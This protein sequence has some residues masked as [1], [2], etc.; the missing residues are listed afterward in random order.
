[1]L[2]VYLRKKT[3]GLCRHVQLPPAATPVL[4]PP[5]V[6]RWSS[7]E[8]GTAEARADR[9]CRCI[10]S[11]PRRLA[12]EADIRE[13]TGYGNAHAGRQ[14]TGLSSAPPTEDG[15]RHPQP[16]GRW[17]G[18][19]IGASGVRST[20]DAGRRIR[21]LCRAARQHRRAR[22]DD[23]A[24]RGNRVRH[25]SAGQRRSRKWLRRR[26]RNSRRHG[27]ARGRRRA[28]GRLDRGS[29]RP[30]DRPIYDQGLAIERVRAA[31]E[32]ARSLSFPFTDGPA[33]RITWSDGP[34][35]KT[36]SPGFR[37][38][39]EAGRTCLCAGPPPWTTLPRS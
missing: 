21:L 10:R 7:R 5:V 17:Y 8:H 11:A 6:G 20:G 36:R 38:T 18:A 15:L 31:V 19:A 14:G 34:I 2:M 28:G 4:N 35:S 1:M 27:S 9:S 25:R 32:A 39:Q 29:D 37:P 13:I 3:S 12:T 24:R 30:S 23:G 22:H 16:V 33:P 26:S